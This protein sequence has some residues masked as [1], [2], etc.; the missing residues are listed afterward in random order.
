MTP[1]VE[2]SVRPVAPRVPPVHWHVLRFMLRQRG[3]A[4][5]GRAA[6]AA[7]GCLG[8]P[9]R[10]LAHGLGLCCYFRSPGRRLA[11]RLACASTRRSVACPSARHV[12]DLT[13]GKLTFT[14][15]TKREGK[16]A[17]TEPP[18][19]RQDTNHIQIIVLFGAGISRPEIRAGSALAAGAGQGRRK[20][21]T[22]VP[23]NAKPVFGI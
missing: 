14:T 10:R 9:R 13:T 12:G 4:G 2:A 20:T 3:G 6:L 5:C 7:A 21:I 18:T 22:V 17:S 15:I 8:P 1:P 11:A 16:A 23:L 19:G